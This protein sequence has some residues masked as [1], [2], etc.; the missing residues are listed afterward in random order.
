MS[1]KYEIKLHQYEGKFLTELLEADLGLLRSSMDCIAPITTQDELHKRALKIL[2]TE[3]IL[4]KVKKSKPKPINPRLGRPRK[5][6]KICKGYMGC[7]GGPTCPG[8]Y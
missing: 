5:P 4:E 3:I 6:C 1:S 2:R 8:A 7:T